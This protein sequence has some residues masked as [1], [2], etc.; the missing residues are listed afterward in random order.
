MK[1][2]LGVCVVIGALFLGI[3][4]GLV[5][6]KTR[7]V[8]NQPKPA[9]TVTVTEPVATQII[10]GAISAHCKYAHYIHGGFGL[11]NC[12]ESHPNPEKTE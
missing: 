2:G 4:S 5:L 6:I 3:V 8:R 1:S 10:N 9:V 11:G 12:E 7:Y